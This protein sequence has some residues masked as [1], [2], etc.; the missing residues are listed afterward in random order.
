[1]NASFGGDGLRKHD[2]RLKFGMCATPYFETCEIGRKRR[3][4][5]K[6][7]EDKRMQEE[8]KSRYALRSTF[9]MHSLWRKEGQIDKATRYSRRG[10][11]KQKSLP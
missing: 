9:S 2:Q 4:K 1:M 8:I 6:A 10:H 7:N 11:R 3:W 5:D